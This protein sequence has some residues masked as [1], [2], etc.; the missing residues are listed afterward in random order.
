MAYCYGCGHYIGEY[1][2]YRRTVPGKGELVLCYKCKQ[3]AERHPEQSRFPPRDA[4]FRMERK[5][6]RTFANIY[7]LSSLGLFAFGVVL[8]LASDKLV[9]AILLLFGAVSLFL[10]GL[11][12]RRFFER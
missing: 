5:R 8:V 11:G 2:A 1:S 3:W 7:I 4:G 9:V 6:V 12:M 10:V